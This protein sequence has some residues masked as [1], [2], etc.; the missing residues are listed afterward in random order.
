VRSANLCR[1]FAGRCVSRVQKLE[2]RKLWGSGLP[3]ESENRHCSPVQRSPAD[4]LANELKVGPNRNCKIMI[5]LLLALLLLSVWVGFYQLM[6]QQG[7]I[8]LRLDALDTTTS[9]HDSFE[10]H[11]HPALEGMPSGAVFPD[12][13]LPDLSGKTRV[14]SEFKGRRLL[15][16]HWN[17]ACG[18]CEAIADDLASLESDLEKQNAQIVLL[19]TGD[20]PFNR[21]RTAVRGLK[22]TV[23][24]LKGQQIPQPFV[25]QGTPVAYFLDERA[26][27]AAPFASGADEVLALAR[28]AAN[29]AGFESNRQRRRLKSERSLAESHIERNGL[30]A[31]TRAPDFRLA[32]L[33]GHT[34]SLDS[35]RGRRVL[36]VFSDPHCGPCDEL[37]PDLARLYQKHRS[38]DFEIILVGRGSKEENRSKSERFGFQFPVVLQD[39]WKLSKEYGIFATPVAFLIAEDGVIAEDVAVGKDAILALANHMARSEERGEHNE[40]AIR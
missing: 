4:L 23:L 15:L 14:L 28:Q 19:S 13:V 31:G 39:K 5:T 38:D 37:A 26:Q 16:I 18:F 11:E 27:V 33:Q 20:E 9:N 17:F 22:T 21:E 25:Q 12:F 40:F 30:K 34:V 32:D 7:R 6:K 36:L 2:I 35:Y 10:Q 29:S 8:L 3:S 1:F 24:L